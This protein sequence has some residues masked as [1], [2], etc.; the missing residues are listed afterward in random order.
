VEYYGIVGQ[1]SRRMRWLGPV[2]SVA[3]TAALAFFPEEPRAWATV[4]AVIPLIA[5][6]TLLARPG[7]IAQAPNRAGLM[8]LGMVYTGVLPALV[9]IVH[10]H[11]PHYVVFLLSIAF[12]GD[13][14]AYTAGRIFGKHPLSAVSPKKTWEGSIGGMIASAGAAAVAA[15]WYMPTFPL[16]WALIVGAIMGALGQLGDLSESLLKRAF[17]VKDSGRMLPGHGGMLDRVDGVLFAAAALYLFV[18]WLP[19]LP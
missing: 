2:V 17:E 4:G 3:I 15:L 10:Q 18:I 7:E 14:G 11:D 1:R 9:A 5:L 6:L 12:L 16:H 19:A 8:A 13:T